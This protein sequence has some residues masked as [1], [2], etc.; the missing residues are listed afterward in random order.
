MAIDPVTG[1]LIGASV[2]GGFFQNRSNRRNQR[3]VN[4]MTVRENRL[5]REHT[6]AENRKAREFT[7]RENERARDFADR[8]SDPAYIRKRAEAAGFNPLTA[9]GGNTAVPGAAGAGAS[10]AQTHAPQIGYQA[11]NLGA[12]ALSAHSEAVALAN[13]KAQLEME[14]ERLAQIVERQTLTPQVPGVYHHGRAARRS[15]EASE[16][17]EEA[18]DNL[19]RS[20]AS[21]PSAGHIAPSDLD[22]LPARDVYNLYS[23]VYDPMTGRTISIP[24]PDLMEMGL[25]ELIGSG[26]TIGAAD[27]SQNWFTSRGDDPKLTFGERVRH[28]FEPQRDVLRG[29]GDVW[30]AFREMNARADRRRGPVRSIQPH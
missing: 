28:G 9:P 26:A 30:D 25:G 13:Q 29:V 20:G 27:L 4:R 16:V 8:T 17:R 2:I 3:S 18:R 22:A 10:S 6:T 15:S 1:A 5:N 14:A 7:A 11:T 23:T 12:L 21:G 19:G 24:N